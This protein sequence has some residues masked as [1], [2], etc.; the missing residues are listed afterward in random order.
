MQPHRSQQ[1]VVFDNFDIDTNDVA[2]YSEKQLVVVSSA[3]QCQDGWEAGCHH[4][5]SYASPSHVVPY[6][7]SQLLPHNKPG[8]SQLQPGTASQV[9]APP[10]AAAAAAAPRPRC[11]DMVDI[12]RAAC[13]LPAVWPPSHSRYVDSRQQICG[14]RVGAGGC[15][16]WPSNT[17]TPAPAPPSHSPSPV[18]VQLQQNPFCLYPVTV[19]HNAPS[20]CLEY[21]SSSSI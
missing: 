4:Y 3:V 5:R 15:M 21:R 1:Y 8:N 9:P 17:S 2:Q 11:V 7:P 19:T 13:T 20:D 10:P 6:S 18:A 16:Q 14:A 12:Q